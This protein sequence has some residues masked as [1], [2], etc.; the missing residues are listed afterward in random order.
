MKLSDFLLFPE[1]KSV[2]SDGL[3]MT[4][5]SNTAVTDA[6]TK[7]YLKMLVAA[8]SMD[9]VRMIVTMLFNAWGEGELD[10]DV[11]R[12]GEVLGTEVTGDSSENATG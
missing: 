7:E 9:E 6:D 12:F 10:M 3:E 8:T 1:E 4:T 5:F 2:S 11:G